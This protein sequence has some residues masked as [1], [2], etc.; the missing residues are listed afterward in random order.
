V[1]VGFMS[2]C[3]HVLDEGERR[4]RRVRHRCIA[5]GVYAHSGAGF[6]CVWWSLV[7]LRGKVDYGT[8]IRS[9]HDQ[10]RGASDQLAC[11]DLHLTSHYVVWPRST[12]PPRT[13]RVAGTPAA[14]LDVLRDQ[15]LTHL[16]EF[17]AVKTSRARITGQR[18]GSM[19]M[20]LHDEGSVPPRTL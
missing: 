3:F 11:G 12:T 2:V 8:T 4:A 15:N 6:A 19:Y 13:T 10:R 14:G 9:D 5:S 17:L 7:T 1:F 16:R 20:A 18:I